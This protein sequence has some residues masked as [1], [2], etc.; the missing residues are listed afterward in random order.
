M[1]F[2]EF[3]L[4]VSFE[5]VML[6]RVQLSCVCLFT[7]IIVASGREISGGRERG[8]RSC[9]QD[10]HDNSC[11]S[12]LLSLTRK[13]TGSFS[14]KTPSL[15]AHGILSELVK[16]NQ[17]ALDNWTMLNWSLCESNS[18]HGCHG[19]VSWYVAKLLVTW[20]FFKF[21]QVSC[22][23]QAHRWSLH[24]FFD[25]QFFLQHL[26]LTLLLSTILSPFDQGGHKTW[27]HASSPN[28]SSD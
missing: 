9:I 15:M 2:H 6:C 8:H 23:S 5:L 16:A 18:N 27:K 21:S 26:P 28:I 12:E 10:G 11:L 22:N 25:L 1:T 4:R 17:M 14:S 20:P 3:H 7:I 24:Q 19:M 13:R